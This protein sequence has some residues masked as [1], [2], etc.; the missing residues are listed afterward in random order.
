VI[1]ET[2][3]ELIPAV[4]TADYPVEGLWSQAPPLE[5]RRAQD[6]GVTVYPTSVRLLED[7][8]RLFVRFDCVDTDVWATHERRD[9]PLW[10]EEV[11][12]MFL[13]PGEGAPSHYVEIQ[14]NPLGTIFDARVS[15]PD[16]RRDTMRVDATWDAPGLTARIGR[17]A[18]AGWRAEI[19][20]PWSDVC[21]GEPPTVWRANILRVERP[22]AGEPEFSCW[23]P[24]LVDPPDFHKPALFGR[25]LRAATGNP[26]LG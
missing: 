16:G 8:R 10:E 12:E 11:V 4:S 21:D 23:S 20:L 3:V 6:G 1:P 25:L 14:V 13:A 5:L 15:N 19:A 17:S 22:R 18:V 26:R 2:R 24:T 7:G 9:A